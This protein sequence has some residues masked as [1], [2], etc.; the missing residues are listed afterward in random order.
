MTASASDAS[1][2]E[3]IELPDGGIVQMQSPRVAKSATA[4]APNPTNEDRTGFFA[5]LVWFGSYRVVRR[6]L[7]MSSIGQ[8][9]ALL[10]VAVSY[11]CV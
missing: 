4:T 9:S 10:R 6:V 3:R 5:R 2:A 7:G 8:L 11:L 1:T